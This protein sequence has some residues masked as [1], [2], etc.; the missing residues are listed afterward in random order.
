PGEIYLD[1][2]GVAFQCIASGTPGTWRRLTLAAPDYDNLSGRNAGSINLLPS[3]LRLYDT[4][5][6]QVPPAPF[7]T[8]KA[9]LNPSTSPS[10]GFDLQVTG[11]AV[12]GVSIP[13]GA[14]GVV[15][16]L[17]VTNTG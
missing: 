12:G 2:T 9:K 13:A 7:P 5:S 3:G 6:G 10:G 11:T 15:G 17:S 4:R 1:S 14:V 16:T 8:T